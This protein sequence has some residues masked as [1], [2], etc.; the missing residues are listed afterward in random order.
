M[1]DA[2]IKMWSWVV[3]IIMGI[4]AIARHKRLGFEAWKFQKDIFHIH[5]DEK[6]IRWGSVGHLIVGIFFV[7]FGLIELLK[8]LTK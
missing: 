3:A 5:L 6:W 7:L 1:S 2:T 8:L 4:C